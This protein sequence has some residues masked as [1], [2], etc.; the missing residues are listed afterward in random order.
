[1]VVEMVRLILTLLRQA[2][3]IFNIRPP[4]S[5]DT[6]GE[7]ASTVNNRAPH[8]GVG[9]AKAV[10]LPPIVFTC[11][12]NFQEISKKDAGCLRSGD[13]RGEIQLG[14]DFRPFRVLVLL[15]VM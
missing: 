5:A 14:L 9:I 10:T 12:I 7:L 15:L 3:T 13:G 11:V 6:E 8:W 1:M 4:T 2:L